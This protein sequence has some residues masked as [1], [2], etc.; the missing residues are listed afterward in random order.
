MAL[1]KR[2]SSGGRTRLA[3]AAVVVV[4]A[5]LVL[6]YYAGAGKPEPSSST[7]S[8]SSAAGPG[9][10]ISLTNVTMSAIPALEDGFTGIGIQAYIFNHST[11]NVDN[12]TISING[13][14]LS[15]CVV[16]TLPPQQ[17]TL[18]KAGNSVACD[19]WPSVP[20]YTIRAEAVFADGTNASASL[21]LTDQL[22][23]SC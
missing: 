2:R 19:V 20:P 1:R 3:I 10:T 14:P 8:T 9:D 11:M 13:I 15:S 18:C 23:T 21:Q 16:S 17:W 12:T 5:L 7:S 4:G 22:T 6:A